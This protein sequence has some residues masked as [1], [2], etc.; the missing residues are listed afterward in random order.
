MRAFRRKSRGA[1]ITREEALKST[2]VKSAEVK[3]E[4]LETGEV[5]LTYPVMVRPLIAS[6]IRQFGGDTSRVQVKKLHLDELGTAVWDLMDGR[7]SVRRVIQGF[8]G[9]YQL[10]IKEAEVAVTRFVRE[11]GKRGLIGLK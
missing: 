1:Q 9:K 6:L 4:R 2:P 5:L 7:R 10:H 8:A 11:L 3:E